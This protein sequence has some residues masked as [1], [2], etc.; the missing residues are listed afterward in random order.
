[1][2]KLIALT[3]ALL[4]LSVPALA[5]T[6]AEGATLTVTGSASVALK[7]DYAQVSVGVSTRA[8]TVNEATEQNG[9]T[10]RSVI[11]ALTQ[12][13]I[14]EA[15]IATSNYSVYAEYEYGTGSAVLSGYCVSNQL[16]VIIR[17]MTAI[18]ATLDHATL[19]GANN[20]YNVQFCS[21]ESAAAQ[22]EA[23]VHAVAEA[24]RKAK[25]LA[26]AAGMEV[27]SILAIEEKTG[28]YV[29]VATTYKA[30]AARDASSNVILPDDLTVSAS[31][32]IVFEL[33]HPTAGQ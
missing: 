23:A 13:G 21:T 30:E 8:A 27:G 14:P 5:E 3:L 26:S 15:D 2:K 7:A 24:I 29:T 6:A 28:G 11:A 19:A 16:T 10:I 25:L 33:V 4:M 17:D 12:A 20:I 18:G 1:M 22:D 9:E 31:V 32:S